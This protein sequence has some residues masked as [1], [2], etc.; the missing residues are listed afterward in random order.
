M[1]ETIACF[2]LTVVLQE[3]DDNNGNW[4]PLHQ[5]LLMLF[6]S[7]LNHAGHLEVYISLADKRII[8][9]HREVRIPRTFKRFE[10]L[11]CNFLQGCDMPVVQTKDGPARLF[12]MVG[13]SLDKIIS[14]SNG[15]ST[16]KYRIRNLTARI[17]SSDYFASSIEIL[18]RA[19]IQIEFGP[20]DFNFLGVG[21]NLE[22]D[23]KVKETKPDSDTYS[24]SHYPLSPCLTC[25]K[26]I[27]AFEKAL[28]IF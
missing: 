8:K 28:D 26:I 22:Y 19:V 15:S 12:Q 5:S 3:Q 1:S 18:K 11:F 2:K 9:L 23:I 17:R 10:Q 13:K 14:T 24:I 25:V 16:I 21:R 6:D 27:T 4:I 7:P 20:V